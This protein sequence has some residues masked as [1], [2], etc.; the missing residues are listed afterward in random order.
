MGTNT[1]SLKTAGLGLKVWIKTSVLPM[2]HSLFRVIFLL[3]LAVTAS[4][5]A[6]VQLLNAAPFNMIMGTPTLL[7][8]T[9]TELISG[10]CYSEVA[11]ATAAGF[12]IFLAGILI[13]AVIIIAL[14]ALH[15]IGEKESRQK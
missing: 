11:I 6:G 10:G 4:Y 12:A 9:P 1:F 14:N 15:E 5:F 13:I 8:E 2:V 3:S 7:C